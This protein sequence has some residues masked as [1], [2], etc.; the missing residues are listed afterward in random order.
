MHRSLELTVPSNITENLCQQLVGLDEVISLSVQIGASRKP[1]GDI[2]SVQVLNKGAD[3]VLRIAGEVVAHPNDLSVA[4]AELSSIIAP[5]E[6]EKILGDKDEAIWEE[7]EAGLRHQGKPTPNYMA[8]MG[9]GGI[10]SAVG[11]VSEPVPQAVAFIASSIISPG[12]EPIAAIPM[13]TVLKRWHVVGR[14]LRSTLL[15]YALFILMAGLTMLCLTAAGESSA[16]ELATN[17]EVKSMAQPSLKTLLVSACGAAAGIIIIAAYR[18]SVIAGALIA[19]ILMP[20]AALIGCGLAVGRSHLALEG[21]SRFGIDMAFVL[22]LGL[23]I[24]YSK[25]RF[26]HRRK[27]LE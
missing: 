21:L 18:R 11:L 4:S 1:V 14:G 19:L 25:Q 24:F 13:G 16:A 2:I 26:L 22:G 6:G 3:D 17:P 20:A 9:L 10:L 5:A 7:I 27:P 12:F 15:G 23:L 8:L